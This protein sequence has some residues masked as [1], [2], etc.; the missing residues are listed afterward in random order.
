[1]TGCVFNKKISPVYGI[2]DLLKYAV[3]EKIAR[4]TRQAN[5]PIL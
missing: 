3:R 4:A 2:E 1:V 5:H